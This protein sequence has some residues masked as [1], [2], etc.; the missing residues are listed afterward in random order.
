[1]YRCGLLA[2]LLCA[3]AAPPQEPAV[4]AAGGVR[5]ASRGP[6]SGDPLPGEELVPGR[7]LVE[8]WSRV[9]APPEEL[10]ALALPSPKRGLT[11]GGVAVRVVREIYSGAGPEEDGGPPLLL[12]ETG[13]K[14]EAG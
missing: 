14:D 8:L 10:A 4:P 2:V 7:A 5:P 1:M 3:C 12:V 9:P 11:L 13:A 6:L